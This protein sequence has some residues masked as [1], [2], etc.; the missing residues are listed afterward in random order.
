MSP[1]VAAIDEAL[2][3][4]RAHSEVMTRAEVEQFKEL[5]ERVFLL[6][7]DNW[8]LRLPQV[9]ELRSECESQELN[10]KP[11][12]F[13]SKLNL[14]GDWDMPTTVE[15]LPREEKLPS[16]YRLIGKVVWPNGMPFLIQH[17]PPAVP[18]PVFLV[19]ATPRW[20]ADMEMLRRLALQAE[21]IKALA[22]ARPPLDESAEG[23][24]IWYHGERSY[25][26][27][28]EHPR[29]VP[30]EQHNVLQ[31]FLDRTISLKTKELQGRGVCN[32][33]AVIGKLAKRFG[34]A[35]IS[36]PASRSEGYSIRVRTL[37]P[38]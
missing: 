20:F 19:C 16:S 22:E 1:L 33:A 8:L 28:G 18:D 3:F 15:E 7:P 5:A 37:K 21:Q 30:P 2:A 17:D 12:Q 14:P 38:D 13:I 32:V 34:A 29:S 26:V 4:A 24:T 31:A 9:T 27:D 25:S 36:R 35:S 6:T 10:R 11:V 23:S